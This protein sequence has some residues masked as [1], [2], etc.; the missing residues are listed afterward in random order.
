VTEAPP[1]GPVRWVLENRQTGRLT[2]AQWPNAPL[3]VW[4]LCTA[5]RRFTDLADTAFDVLGTVGLAV[6]AAL[7]IWK[8]VNP[9]RR[10][11]GVFALATIALSLAR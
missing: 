10:I 4:I 7:E 3:W 1:R 9:F 11:L 2:I 6:W 5:L 8:G